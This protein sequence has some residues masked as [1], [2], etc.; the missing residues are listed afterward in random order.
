MFP[1]QL[2][3]SWYAKYNVNSHHLDSYNWFVHQGLRQILQ[4]VPIT[5]KNAQDQVVEIVVDNLQIPHPS[6]HDDMRKSTITPYDCR[7]CSYTYATQV[8]VSLKEKQGDRETF[9]PHVQLCSIPVMLRSSVCILSDQ[10]A[11]KLGECSMDPGGYFIINGVERVLVAQRRDNYNHCQVYADTGSGAGVLRTE[12]R[13]MS[14]DTNHS[15]LVQASLL[16]DQ[17]DF[18]I[19]IPHITPVSWVVLLKALGKSVDDVV[20]YA[21]QHLDERI[22]RKVVTK[23]WTRYDAVTTIEQALEI[24]GEKAVKIDKAASLHDFGV[25]V[26]FVEMFPHLGAFTTPDQ[27]ANTVLYMFV[28]AEK[29]FFRVLQPEDRDNIAN[30]R[31]ETSGVLMYELF[32]SLYR[33]AVSNIESAYTKLSI[34]EVF[35]QIS[36]DISKNINYCF[37]TGKWGIQRNSYIREGV[38]QVMSRL[39]FVAMLSHLQRVVIPTGKE[40]K[41]FKIR[42]IHPS[43]FGYICHYETPE[44]GKCG[45]VGNF[46]I[47][48]RISQH[49]PY[50]L[51]RAIVL[52]V[53]S[54][55]SKGTPVFLNGVPNGFVASGAE[56]VQ[57]IKRLRASK[58][59][60][61]DVSIMWDSV[62]NEIRV[63]CD[64]G[65][66]IRPFLTCTDYDSSSTFQDLEDS[67]TIVWLDSGE[68]QTLR[69]GMYPTEKADVWELHP[70]M[71]IG[72]CSGSIPFLD[73]N[74]SPRNVYESSMMKQ[75]VGMFAQN[76]NQRYDSSYHVLSYPQKSLVSTFIS[77][78]VGMHEMPA[79]INC[80]VAICTH[81]A[82]NAEDSIIINRAAVERGLF[83][84]NSFHTCVYEIST[85]QGRKVCVPPEH[86]RKR[87]WNYF[88]LDSSGIVRERSFINKNDVVLGQTKRINEVDYDCSELSEYDGYVD[89]VER[90]Q[91]FNGSEQ[92]KIIIRQLRIPEIG[93]KFAN[94]DAQKGTCALIANTEDLPFT[95]DG[96]VPDILMNS[97]AMPSR[98]TISMLLSMVL[99]KI[100]CMTGEYADA[101][102]FSD[103]SVNIVDRLEKELGK[104]G[105][106]RYGSDVM[107]NG[108]TGETLESRIFIGISYYQRLKHLCGDK[109]HARSFG[110]VTSL[111]RQPLAGRSKDGG[112]RVSELQRDCL[113]SHGSLMFLRERLTDMS[114]PFSVMVCNR[115]K[116]I[117]NSSQHCHLCR[118]AVGR[119]VL[120]YASKLLFQ[121]LMGATIKLSIE[122]GVE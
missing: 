74:Q 97:H 117:S 25:Q 41:N 26:L 19:S 82:W 80:V 77:R 11:V 118:G 109:V 68:A 83:F 62:E 63:F 104:H 58:R 115:C 71:M 8:Y 84:S 56:Q 90:V 101:T 16:E 99:G 2:L 67:G 17:D 72:I 32:K 75:A 88:N 38:S 60:P 43:S 18:L 15:V 37:T 59:L 79:G 95:S 110:N 31:Y 29:V 49:H 44:G 4:S 48:S 14:D 36:T 30:K 46:S 51:I 57:V 28:K 85:F 120:N 70:S 34:L 64:K 69:V 122:Y 100:S 53:L 3:Q 9:Y 121:L 102:P 93:D 76:Y 78:Q 73:H 98:M 119:V 50:A 92:V 40:G 47:S 39:S 94:L 55:V 107:T 105:F 54:R 65:R 106:D 89:R 111:T 42:Q 81:G 113:V 52:R 35:K 5:F 91:C 45:I 20:E 33:S 23:M 21:A 24:I 27:I 116:I 108:A 66:L 7:K 10:D 96:I 112:L 1:E 103:N 61:H 86:L 87:E 13:S 12:M 22:I 6:V 114:D